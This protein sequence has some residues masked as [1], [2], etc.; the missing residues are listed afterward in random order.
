MRYLPAF[1]KELGKQRHRPDAV[2]LYVAKT[3]RRFPGAVP[4]LPE[5]PDWVTVIT[6]EQDFG[7][8]TKILPAVHKW[9]D[10][11]IDILF[12]DDDQRYDRFWAGRFAADRRKC[13]DAVLCE[14]GFDFQYLG[15]PIPPNPPQP[16][17]RKI[18]WTQ[19]KIHR[20]KR[21]LSLG[22]YTPPRPAY[23]S[24]AYVDIV[25]GFRGIS[26]KPRFFDDEVF[27]IPE[28]LWTVDDI[29]L[30]GHLTR[31]G[32]ALRTTSNPMRALL[33]P[34]APHDV[35]PL[36]THSEEGV[37]RMAANIQCVRYF[38]EKYGIWQ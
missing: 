32:H 11:D 34:E 20:A 36:T 29:W 18:T 7:P 30:S 21:V 17:L 38:Q 37:G 12:C 14:H 23:G 33:D 10:K 25:E 6:A 15:L 35:A 26:V 19:R 13:P 16:R 1:F 31:T 4:S 5:L 24:W 8:A 3:Y 27:D 22:M 28:I 9:R 2:E